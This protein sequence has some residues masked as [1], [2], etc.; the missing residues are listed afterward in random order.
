MR[1]FLPLLKTWCLLAVAII[2]NLN[3]AKAQSVV[4]SGYIFTASSK[5]FNYVTGGTS[6]SAIEVDDNWANLPIGFTFTF[7]GVDYTDVCVCSNGWLRFGTGV[8]TASPNWNSNASPGSGIEPAVFALYEDLSGASGTA[9]Y[10]VTGSSPNRVFTMEWR[11]WLW[12]YAASNP[13]VTF[14][15]KLYETS[16]KIECIYKQEPGAVAVNSSGGASIGISRTASDW[17]VLTDVSSAPVSSSTTYTGTLSNTPAT[18]Q[19]YEWDP[20]AP[21]PKPTPINITNFNSKGVT[22]DWPVIS[23]S[24][25][26]EYIVDKNS[27][28]PATAGTPTTGNSATVGGLTPSTTY[29]IHVRNKC[30]AFNISKWETL[31][32][33]TRPDCTEPQNIQANNVDSNSAIIYWTPVPAASPYQ[34]I[35]DNSN[36]LIPPDLTNVQSTTT[37]GMSLTPLNSGVDYYVHARSLCAGNDSSAWV[38]FPF[39]TP[40]SCKTPALATTTVSNHDAVIYWPSINTAMGYEYVLDQTQATP[41]LGTP[42]ASPYFHANPLAS[43]ETYYLHARAMCTDH[44]INTTSPWALVEFHT[45][46]PTGIAA[47]A[48]GIAPGMQLSPNPVKSTLVVKVNYNTNNVQSIS[49]YNL[50]GQL[51][52][53]VAMSKNECEINMEKLPAGQYIVTY[54]DGERTESQSVIKQ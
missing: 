50:N 9:N 24:A 17:Q 8:G 12:D 7:C 45:L 40:L 42:I 20:G 33:Q 36:V 31:S 14:Q 51:V 48:A 19:S 3:Q 35:V 1:S 47:L 21:C 2:C 44:N 30:S 38:L 29:Y 53:T 43:D 4:A 34:Y 18:G 49:V 13:C 22:F 6:V 11:N 54:K 41:P 37:N 15:V 25:G 52:K 5:T 16:N 23:G 39:H 28:S 46:P 32:F 26:Y 10:V 27:G